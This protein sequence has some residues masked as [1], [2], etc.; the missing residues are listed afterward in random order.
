M[1]VV[2]NMHPPKTTVYNTK[3]VKRDKSGLVLCP[4]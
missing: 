1:F 3:I 4:T 2:H